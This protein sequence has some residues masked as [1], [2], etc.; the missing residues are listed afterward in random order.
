MKPEY[1]LNTLAVCYIML[2][3]NTAMSQQFSAGFNCSRLTNDETRAECYRQTG[4]TAATYGSSPRFPVGFDCSRLTNDET[5]EICLT[6]QG[7][8][9]A[10]RRSPSVAQPKAISPPPIAKSEPT[11]SSTGTGFF[12][13]SKGHVISNAHVVKGCERLV[14][15]RPN[16]EKFPLNLVAV[17][18]RNDLALLK[19]N[20]AGAF[21]AF[22]KGPA[23]LGEIVIVYGFPLAGT[24]A[25]TG[26]L[27]TGS[28]SG[29]A[30]LSN[31]PSQ[32]QVSAPVQPG[33]SGGPVL[34][35]SGL[36]VGV[37][38][39]KLDALRAQKVT[40]DIPQN[41]NFAIKASVA[42]NF[43]DAEGVRYVERSQVPSRKASAVA[44]EAIRFTVL[45]ACFR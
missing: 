31:D 22:R 29:L 40:G 1:A 21:A 43:L 24:L 12:V 8:G 16:G 15:R 23:P 17:D 7:R 2:A 20:V 5:R 45:I 3:T 14:A 32:Y 19:S 9:G 10:E 28:I 27:T 25:I 4:G 26:N 41:I 39:S 11:L 6:E 30:G 18:A 38:Q 37:V 13:S 36:V 44:D 34:D 33:N 42:Q 35:D